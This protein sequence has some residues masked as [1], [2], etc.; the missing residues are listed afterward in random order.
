[1]TAISSEARTNTIKDLSELLQ[2]DAK[3]LGGILELCRFFKER[4]RSYVGVGLQA[5]G[6]G[7]ASPTRECYRVL[8]EVQGNRT[9]LQIISGDLG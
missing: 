1:M 4:R 2:G 6:D 5:S 9:V 8:D 3:I 7:Q